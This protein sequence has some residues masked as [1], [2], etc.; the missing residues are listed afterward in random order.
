MEQIIFGQPIDELDYCERV[1]VYAVI[2]D[3]SRKLIASVQTKRG[4]YFLPGGG[5]ENNESD[6]GCLKRELLEETGFDVEIK[7]Y[8]GEAKLYFL[9]TRNEPIVSTG[10]FYLASLLEKIQEPVDLDHTLQWIS[11]KDVDRFLVF[12]HHK[13]AV[14]RA[15]TVGP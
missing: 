2:F 5:V 10:H 9:S 1:G 11:M 8:V 4:H 7:R 15:L 13:W 14:K 12:D 6:E 3:V